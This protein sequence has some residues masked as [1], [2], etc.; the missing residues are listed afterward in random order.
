M[1][2]LN[3]FALGNSADLGKRQ[4]Q[5]HYHLCEGMYETITHERAD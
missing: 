1:V 5:R 4:R 2:F 3:E